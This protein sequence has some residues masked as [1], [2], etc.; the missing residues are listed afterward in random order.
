MKVVYCD[1]CGNEADY[2]RDNGVSWHFDKFMSEMNEKYDWEVCG[3]CYDVIKCH[4]DDMVATKKSENER[5]E[6]PREVG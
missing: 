2:E 4:I 3:D 1:I 5:G 6:E